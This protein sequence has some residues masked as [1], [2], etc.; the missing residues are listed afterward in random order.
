[1][2]GA[3]RI[4]TTVKFANPDKILS[5]L[6]LNPGGD[7][8]KFFMIRARER[9]KPY[10]PYREFGSFE[11]TIDQNTDFEN[12]RFIIDLEYARKLY[13]GIAP[14]GNPINYTK[15]P[16]PKAGPYFDRMMMAAEGEALVREVQAYQRSHKNG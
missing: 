11:D 13:N 12:A 2:G 7:V 6:G 15:R 1:M 14:S 4:A 9:M 3:C 8:H 10:M 5:N 16:H